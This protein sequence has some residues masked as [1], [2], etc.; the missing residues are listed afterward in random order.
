MNAGKS[1]HDGPYTP[2]LEM[3][4]SP[5]AKVGEKSCTHEDGAG[6]R[7]AED[8]DGTDEEQTRQDKE[9]VQV[10]ACVLRPLGRWVELQIDHASKTS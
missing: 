8:G 7:S 6:E 1:A 2:E 10:V 9:E 4:I 3:D 5:V